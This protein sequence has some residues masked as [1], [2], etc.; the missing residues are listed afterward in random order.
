MARRLSAART[1]FGGFT[2]ELSGAN[3]HRSIAADA[4]RASCRRTRRDGVTKV[5]RYGYPAGPGP[6]VRRASGMEKSRPGNDADASRHR[7]GLSIGCAATLSLDPFSRKAL[8]QTWLAGRRTEP[9]LRQGSGRDANRSRRAV[10]E[11]DSGPRFTM[12]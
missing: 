7:R 5:S 9:L 10:A 8:P 2:E 12:E 6:L 4:C 3:E 11:F 1:N